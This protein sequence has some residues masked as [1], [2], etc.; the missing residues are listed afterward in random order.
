MVKRFVSIVFFSDRFQVLGLNS[1]LTSIEKLA[2]YQIPEGMVRNHR[3][4]DAVKLSQIIRG[5][6]K[7]MGIGRASVGIVVPEFSSYTKLLAMPKLPPDETHEAILWKSQ[8]FLPSS[9][10]HVLDWE[11]IKENS[12][13]NEVLVASIREDV[14]AGYAQAVGDAG[15][16][17]LVVETPSLSLVRMAPDHNKGKLVVY[18]GP[19]EAVLV[20][21]V[22]RA[23]FGSTVISRSDMLEVLRTAVRMTEH[24][25]EVKVEQLFFGGIGFD[26]DFVAK[27]EA[28]V[29]IKSQA[30]GGDLPLSS[31][32]QF[33]EYMIAISSQIKDPAQ[34]KSTETINLLPYHWVRHYKEKLFDAQLWSLSLAAAVVILISFVA[35]AGAYMFLDGELGQVD[36]L[37]GGEVVE[38][39]ALIER[40]G[41]VN[42]L[43]KKINEIGQEGV[44]PQ[45]I[46]NKLIA[47]TPGNV[48]VSNYFVSGESGQVRV[49]G[50][51][52]D[53]AALI[54]YRQALASSADFSAPVL[55]ISSLTQEQDVAFDLT[56]VYLELEKK[57]PGVPQRIKI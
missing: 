51:A 39:K 25:K 37:N 29:G 53:R 3:V 1:S 8:E 48:L 18:L 34:P 28:G 13:N 17:P 32:P 15:L 57:A 6:W 2:T 21:A 16:L 44:R 22:G 31:S 14:L 50:V 43:A 40:V 20:I 33:G 30:M 11:I 38:D 12:E 26:A 23:I 24:Y 19:V 7:Q 4:L 41:R 36:R 52:L 35:G 5:V 54:G 10:R 56:F 55:P 46:I 49:Q 42:N 27:L 9:A 45:I 47:I